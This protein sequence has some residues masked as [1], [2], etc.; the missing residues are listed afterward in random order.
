MFT[1]YNSLAFFICISTKMFESRCKLLFIERSIYSSES[2]SRQ[3][4][5]FQLSHS[6]CIWCVYVD[7]FMHER[8]LSIIIST[9][10]FE[11]S[12]INNRWLRFALKSTFMSFAFPVI[13]NGYFFC[14]WS[15]HVHFLDDKNARSIRIE[16]FL[17]RNCECLS[18]LRCYFFEVDFD[19]TCHDVSSFVGDE[20]DVDF[21]SIFSV[22]FFDVDVSVQWKY[23]RAIWL[24]FR[25]ER[26]AGMLKCESAGELNW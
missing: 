22:I 11:I 17:K 13:L 1:G 7:S 4:F 21:S 20:I 5:F 2:Y 12:D 6:W 26:F 25:G 24:Y 8:R 23:I 9:S 3:C 14:S 16:T 18:L 19:Y 10:W 15:T